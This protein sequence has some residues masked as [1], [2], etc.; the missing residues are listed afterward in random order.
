MM[1]RYH[2]DLRNAYTDPPTE[3]GEYLCYIEGEWFITN[4]SAK[5]KAFNVYDEWPLPEVLKHRVHI[6]LWA[7][8]PEIGA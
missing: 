8:L 5:H 4:Y 3:S 1:K 7:K 2:I 6:S